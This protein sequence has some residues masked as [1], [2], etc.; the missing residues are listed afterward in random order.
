MFQA[1]CVH[2]TSLINIITIDSY[3][4]PPV[5]S[6]NAQSLSPTQLLEEEEEEEEEIDPYVI[7]L[8][9]AAEKVPCNHLQQT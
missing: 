7:D 9:P 4:T 6:I 5:Q 8:S 1:H 2:Y 3:Q